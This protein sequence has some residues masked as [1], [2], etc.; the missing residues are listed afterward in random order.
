MMMVYRSVPAELDPSALALVDEAAGLLAVW[1]SSNAMDALSQRLS[2]ATW[3]RLCLGDWL[4]I[5]SRLQ[6]LAAAYGPAQV[7]LADGPG[8]GAILEAIRSLLA[9]P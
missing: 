2:S 7:H 9:V 3:S 5:S 1:T 6:R 8:N 4:V